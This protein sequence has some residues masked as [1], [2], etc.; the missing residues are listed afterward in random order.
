MRPVARRFRSEAIVDS[1]MYP[2]TASAGLNDPWIQQ[3]A[4]IDYSDLRH[5]IDYWNA[6]GAGFSQVVLGETHSGNINT[7]IVGQCDSYPATAATSNVAGF[8]SST[9]AGYSVVFQP[10]MNLGGPC[11]PY[12]SGAQD[13]YQNVNYN[14]AGPYTPTRQ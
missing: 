5:F 4:T 7:N 8:N 1:H 13:N 10:W 2:H 11:W 6:L 3:I 14:G 12:N 9:Q